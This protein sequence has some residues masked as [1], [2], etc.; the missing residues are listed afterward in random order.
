MLKYL[1]K[2]PLTIQAADKADPQKI[3]E[4]LAAIAAG[5]KGELTPPAVVDA[6]RDKKSA[7]HRHFEWSDQVAAEKYRLDQARS[8]I[9]SIHVEDDDA[10][11]GHLQAYISVNDKGGVSYRS[12]G[13][14]K[15]SADL[16]AK[17]LVQAEKDLEA[18]TKRY[19]SLADV[20]QIIRQAQELVKRKRQR[21]ET[22]AQA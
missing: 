13:D 10:E 12:L 18:W 16:Q 1:F 2:E 14:I 19:R 6:A 20:C 3:G 9:R 15:N 5:N 17:V 11:D 21:V 4:A 22:R 8:L 7:L